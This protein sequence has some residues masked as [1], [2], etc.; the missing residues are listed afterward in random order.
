MLQQLDIADS[1]RRKV[2]ARIAQKHKA[3]DVERLEG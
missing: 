3:E 2:A 1:V